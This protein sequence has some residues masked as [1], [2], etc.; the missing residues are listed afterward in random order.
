MLLADRYIERNREDEHRGAVLVGLERSTLVCRRTVLSHVRVLEVTD[1]SALDG[2]RGLVVFPRDAGSAADSTLRLKTVQRPGSPK[3]LFG[4]RRR[5]L[6]E[7]LRV[8]LCRR[9]VLLRRLVRVAGSYVALRRVLLRRIGLLW[10]LRN[11][12][13]L[14]V[15]I[16]H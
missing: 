14:D 1:L 4:L 9:C 11:R 2:V 6:L 3:S 5:Y 16:G 12:C 10:R 13:L 7:H 15:R 8:R